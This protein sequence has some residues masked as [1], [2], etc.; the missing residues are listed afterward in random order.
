MLQPTSDDQDTNMNRTKCDGHG[1]KQAKMKKKSQQQPQHQEIDTSS[2]LSPEELQSREHGYS[3]DRLQQTFHGYIDADVVTLVAG[4]CDYVLSD[5]VDCLVNM[6][7]TERAQ[8]KLELHKLKNE[9]RD[10]YWRQ[11][12]IEDVY[13]QCNYDYRKTCEELAD[14]IDEAMAKQETSEA[15]QKASVAKKKKPAAINDL[16]DLKDATV[17]GPSFSSSSS[18][19]KCLPPPSNNI[20]LGRDNIEHLQKMFEKKNPTLAWSAMTTVLAKAKASGHLHVP[21][22]DSTWSAIEQNLERHLNPKPRIKTTPVSSS[23][24]GPSTSA[25]GPKKSNRNAQKKPPTPQASSSSRKTANQSKK[26]A[27][28]EAV[29]ESFQEIVAEQQATAESAEEYAHLVERKLKST[30]KDS[31]EAEEMRQE[32]FIE[33]CK[34]FLLQ[35]FPGFEPSI[36]ISLLEANA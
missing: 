18:S 11:S 20:V 22:D 1:K 3:L 12:D 17:P 25:A 9:F 28:T 4:N 16:H 31:T 29:V 19:S 2:T 23:T 21:L 7:N 5:T 34:K 24:S 32:M 26:W 6:M 33:S 13:Q 36:L 27:S 8:R 15:Q 10:S 30:T 14:F 35:N